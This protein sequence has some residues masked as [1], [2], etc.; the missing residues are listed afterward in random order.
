LP[1]LVAHG[2]P[3]RRTTARIGTALLGLALLCGLSVITWWRL[4]PVEQRTQVIAGQAADSNLPPLSIAVLPFE[5]LS[6]DP[7]QAYLADGISEDLTTDLSHLD[8]AFVIARES[9][10]SYRGKAVDVRDVGRQLGVR[11]VLE[12]SVRKISSFVRI[13]AQLIAT[14]TGAHLWAEHFDKPT[15]ELGEGQ[16]DIVAHLLLAIADMRTGRIEEAQKS[17]KE[18]MAGPSMR[19]VTARTLLRDFR[20]FGDTYGD[21]HKIS[22][23]RQF[24]ED[25]RRAGLRDHLD[26]DADSGVP[27]TSELQGII[28]LDDPTPM[29]IPG[30]RMVRTPEVISMLATQAPLV[31]TTCVDEPTVPGAIYVAVPETG[32]LQDDWQPKVQKLMQELIHGDHN[33]QIIVF[34]CTINRWISRNLALRIMVLGYTNVAWYR[35]GWEAWDAS[36]TTKGRFL[37]RRSL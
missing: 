17:L 23:E 15:S 11:Y 3:T 2:R 5:N 16:D 18:A 30:G 21:D 9:A 22:Q 31:L 8:N 33:R 6:G 19:E 35:G 24:V 7:E 13:T 36:G 1:P 12:G 34:A 20:Q 26:E 4:H 28:H 25:L 32:S 29:T 37:A 14:D 10:F 27:S